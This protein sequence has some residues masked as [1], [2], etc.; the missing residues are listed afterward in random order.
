MGDFDFH[1][2]GHI[3]AA[4]STG[5]L[6]RDHRIFYGKSQDWDGFPSVASRHIC[7]GDSLASVYLCRALKTREAGSLH[8]SIHPYKRH[9][10][11]HLLGA[12]DFRMSS[13]TSKIAGA[14]AGW[15]SQ[16]VEK[17][18]VVLSPQ[19]GVAPAL[20]GSTL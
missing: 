14:N 1:R 12:A 8:G 4:S 11:L 16:F 5:F 20:G 9:N 17:S 13:R 6:P 15:R 18:R 7:S 3:V 19:P 10:Q 2:S